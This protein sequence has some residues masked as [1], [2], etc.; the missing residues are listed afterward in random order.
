MANSTPTFGSAGLVFTDLSIYDD[1]PRARR[2]KPDGKILVAG[3][4]SDTFCLARYNANGVLDATLAA[5]APSSY[6]AAAQ[7]SVAPSPLLHDG[8]IVIAGSVFR[9]MGLLPLPSVPTA[10]S[11]RASQQRQS[12]HPIGSNS[13]IARAL[14]TATRWQVGR[15][16]ILLER[17]QKRRLPRPLQPIGSLDT[18]FNTTG[19][20]ISPIGA[21]DGVAT[22]VA[23]QPDGKIV[24]AGIAQRQQQRFLPR[25]LRGG[26]FDARNC[27][28]D[29]DGD[30]RVLAT[31]DIL[32]GA[33]VALGP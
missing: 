5:A 18:S 31:T 22:A 28:M 11:T 15:G 16:G 26:P 30:N 17:H 8:R 24:V 25:A 7:T 23:L 4:C 19:K 27:S 3:S 20:L 33:R 14:R 32:I 1:I 13:D 10:R 9:R 12:R 29:I 2:A 21:N 6:S